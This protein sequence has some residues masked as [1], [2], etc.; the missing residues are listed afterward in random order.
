MNKLLEKFKPADIIAMIVLVGGLGL[1]FSGADGLVG[2]LLTAVVVYYFGDRT[3]LAPLIRKAEEKKEVLPVEEIIRA[4]A[5][6]QGVD[7]D[8]AVRVA[9]CESG[10]D[11]KA[12]HVNAKGSKDRG[13]FQWN[14]KYHPEIND[15]Y[16]FDPK[17]AT[18]EFCKAFKNGNISWWNASKDCWKKD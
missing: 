2:I 15:H 12:V 9:R 14:D 17:L 4:E 18:R 13:I 8:F 16:A 5:K 7:P 10:L 6:A 3:V 11:P 1:K